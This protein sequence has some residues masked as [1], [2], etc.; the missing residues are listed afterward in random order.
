MLL[1]LLTMHHP[2]LNRY[3]S[4]SMFPPWQQPNLFNKPHPNPS[5]LTTEPPT[6]NKIA[7][8]ASK[9]NIVGPD[10][11][12]NPETTTS[13][14]GPLPPLREDA[15]STPRGRDA[16]GKAKQYLHEAEEESFYL[17]AR[18]RYYLFRPG[19]A[20]GLIGL[21]MRSI[22]SW[23]PF[24]LTRRCSSE[25]WSHRLCWVF[26]LLQTAPPP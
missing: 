22:S 24:L 1:S 19:V 3:I 10:F 25:C 6:A 2:R 12:S 26:L 21:G 8:D 11:R 9:V 17:Y 13:I 7:D 15:Y 20:G 16:K 4:H 14:S 5:L 18:A 23:F